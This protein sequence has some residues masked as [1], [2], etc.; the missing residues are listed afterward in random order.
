MEE[1]N[2]LISEGKLS[3]ACHLA[4]HRQFNDKSADFLRTFLALRLL[5]KKYMEVSHADGGKDLVSKSLINAAKAL[6]SQNTQKVFQALSGIQLPAENLTPFE[7]LIT[8]L[9]SSLRHDELKKI[10]NVYSSIS[11][12]Q[13]QSHLGLVNLENAREV[14]KSRNWEVCQDDNSIV[15]PNKINESGTRLLNIGSNGSGGADAGL[16]NTFTSYVSHFEK[17]PLSV[18]IQQISKK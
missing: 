16:L 18:D 17:K 1:I 8:R 12:N 3:N 4:T 5:S 7:Y 6:V 14:V 15:Y 9:I 10:S 2:Q 13:L 11:L